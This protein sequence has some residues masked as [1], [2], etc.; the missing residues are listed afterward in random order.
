MEAHGLRTANAAVLERELAWLAR[1]VE[2]SLAADG[3]P[4]VAHIG[5]PDT[6]PPPL[7]DGESTYVGLV[8]QH[9]MGL[10]ER[11]VFILALTPHIRPQLLDGFFKPNEALGRGRTEYGGIQGRTHGGFLPTGETAL[12]LLAGDDLAK[13][14]ESERIFD[15]DHFFAR[16]NILRLECAAADE[17]LLSGQLVV[18]DGIVDRVTAGEL[19]KPDYSREFPARLLSTS[20]EWDDL[21]LAPSTRDQIRELEAWLRFEGQLMGDTGLG[22]RLRPGYRCLFHGPPGTGKTLA[23]T[24]IGKRVGRDIYRIALSSVVSKYIGE[25]EKN[26]ERVFMRAEGMR[27]CILFFDEADALFG[28]RTSVSDAHDRY[29]NQEVSYLLQRVEDYSGVA[30]LAS[31]FLGNIDEAFMRRFQAV[32]LFPMPDAVERHRLW[33][34]SLP[35][36]WGLEEA[37]RLEDLAARFELSGATIMNVVRY[38]TL[39]ALAE[40]S[41]LIRQRHLMNGIR[42]E[43]QKEG[44]TM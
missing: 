28:K 20:M 19:R 6:A 25:T 38:A 5:L 32:I 34:D 44:K 36:R 26:L 15:R 31:N 16:C 8:R 37:V 1:V 22:R 40:D 17:P 12:F 9:G 43:L 35:Q 10:E 27:N 18:A 13:R 4:K 29:A 30:I 11:L 21:V 14:F 2:P 39:M 42:R 33:R 24:V 7:E 23:A 3:I 41:T